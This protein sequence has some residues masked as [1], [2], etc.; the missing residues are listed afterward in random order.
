MNNEHI[1]L[2][3]FPSSISHLSAMNEKG[4][5]VKEKEFRYMGF[6]RNE[7]YPILIDNCIEKLFVSLLL[8]KDLYLS[9]TD[10]LKVI[11]TIGVPN[12]IILLERKIIKILPRYQDPHVIVHKSTNPLITKT[13]HELEPIMYLGGLRELDK[14][15]K[16]F[17]VNESYKAK[18]VQYFENAHVVLRDNDESIF[19]RNIEILKQEEKFNFSNLDYQN[20]FRALRLYGVVESYLLQEKYN[21]SNSLVD[22]YGQKYLES[23]FFINNRNMHS[24]EKKLNLF[25]NISNE[26]RIPDFYNMF[27]KGSI[28]MNQFLDLRDSF[29]SKLF[30]NWFTN[31]DISEQEIYYELMKKHEI[32][33]QMNF[34]KWLVP[35]IIGIINTPL[36]VVASAVDNYF[37]SK[38]L[39]GWNPNLFLDDVLGKKLNKLEDQFNLEKEREIILQRF[40]GIERNALCPCQSGKK[41][42]KCH[43][44]NI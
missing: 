24:S 38:I 16:K 12:A 23:K 15:Y 31:P 17:S 22:D 30:R 32:N 6:I 1:L 43:G 5:D 7:D 9:D 4:E 37:I 36:G 35:T 34:I 33:F 44:V 41:F 29:N 8:Y 26:K 40:K 39:Q 2:S 11:Q 10:F 21:L 13:W 18:I 42:K 25:V 28:G 27:K 19:L 3:N 20:T 14:H